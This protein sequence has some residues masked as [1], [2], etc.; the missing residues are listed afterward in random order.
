M[1]NHELQ[2]GSSGIN[3]TEPLKWSRLC[4]LDSN[5]LNNIL[6][7]CGHYIP[8][9]YKLSIYDILE[10]RGVKPLY[11]ITP[12]ESNLIHKAYLTKREALLRNGCT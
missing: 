8:M 10:K 7:C 1:I 3:G 5:H 12:E 2:W 9:H 4:D 11:N 6:A